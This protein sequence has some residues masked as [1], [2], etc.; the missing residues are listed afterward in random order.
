[1][2]H[3]AC[4]L[5]LGLLVACGAGKSGEDTGTGAAGTSTTGATT[6]APTSSSSTG[7]PTSAAPTTTSSTGT[8]DLTS[9]GDESCGTA[10]TSEGGNFLPGEPDA[11]D[12]LACDVL[13]ED[14]PAGQKCMPYVDGGDA[15]WNALK[16]VPVDPAPVGVGEA[17]DAPGNGLTGV[18]NCD[19]HVMCWD[20]E[21]D[22]GVC[23]AMCVD[24][25]CAEGFNCFVANDGILN[26]CLQACDV[27]MPDCP[28][29]TGCLPVV[30]GG[31]CAPA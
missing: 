16:C 17:C 2:K 9:T 8:P 3:L 6:D 19:K 10:C 24:D 28:P 25:G 22:M 13:A 7:G 15:L 18:D 31:V 1:V 4:T 30:D 5:S 23:A 20:V 29:G 14:C 26:L 11:G 27:N 21:N 12:K